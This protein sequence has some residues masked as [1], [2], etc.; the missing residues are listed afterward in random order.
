MIV[1]M[2]NESQKRYST[3]HTYKNAFSVISNKKDYFRL[4]FVKNSPKVYEQ[5]RTSRNTN[6]RKWR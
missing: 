3:N 4:V 2:V 1:L 6:F 5:R